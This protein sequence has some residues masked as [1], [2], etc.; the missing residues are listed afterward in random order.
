M[1]PHDFIRFPLRP[2]LAIVALLSCVGT[3]LAAQATQNAYLATSGS[4]LL[5]VD[6]ATG[7][8]STL[9]TTSGGSYRKAIMGPGNLYALAVR[10]NAGLSDAWLVR[11][12]A[13]GAQTTVSTVPTNGAASGIAIDQDARAVVT[14][15]DGLVQSIFLASV[16]TIA[17]SAGLRPN[18]ICM[19]DDTGD[20]IVASYF[21]SSTGGLIRI[22]RAR[23]TATTITRSFP[24]VTGC[25][26]DQWTGRF[27]A[28]TRV[29]PQLRVVNRDGSIHTTKTFAHD[30]EGVRI[31][32]VTGHVHV[33]GGGQIYHLDET[34]TLVRT[35]GSFGFLSGIDL[36]GS[37]F[38]T[39]SGTAAHGSAYWV[40][41]A[42]PNQPNRYY[43][44]ALGGS[45]LRPGWR[46][47]NG[48][49]INIQLDALFF[50]TLA[51]NLPFFTERFDGTTDASGR[52]N[53]RF[54]LPNLTAAYRLTFSASV[55]D[56]SHPDKIVTSPSL[57]VS[58]R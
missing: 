56:P 58:V 19:D 12:A 41:G 42:F 51:G 17:S 24:G 54:T 36:W 57:T 16:T 46:R 32:D 11:I 5:L 38:L 28:T 10:A 40:D 9:A 52:F 27:L 34:L 8:A 30:L 44:A 35:Y 48:Q 37:R 25:D 7:V 33:V 21:N 6:R 43:V 29:S 53:A 15:S 22:D 49:R 20:Y 2:V 39:G 55:L 18:G 26:H 45:G 4:R 13:S 31:D 3:P 14:T 50:A 1:Q 23:R 47:S